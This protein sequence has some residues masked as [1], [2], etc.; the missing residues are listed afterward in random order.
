MLYQRQMQTLFLQYTATESVWFDHWKAVVHSRTLTGAVAYCLVPYSR[1]HG[2]VCSCGILTV[3]DRVRSKG[4]GGFLLGYF[5]TSP[6]VAV[7]SV[8]LPPSYLCPSRPR[9]SLHTLCAK[10]SMFNNFKSLE[11]INV[12]NKQLK[13]LLIELLTDQ[14][15]V[16]TNNNYIM[17]VCFQQPTSVSPCIIHF[18]F[19]IRWHNL[20]TAEHLL[21]VSK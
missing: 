5:R 19:L 7:F 3:F 17:Y 12:V 1:Q 8:V 14:R 4:R 20:C 15:T 6:Q 2:E 9:C 11:Q 10:H 16:L 21:T 13:V 18:I